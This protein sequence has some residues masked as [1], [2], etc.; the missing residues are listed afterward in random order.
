MDVSV[1]MINYNTFALAKDAVDSIFACTKGVDYEVILVDNL[2]P[3][4]SGER[5]SA[6]FG[7]K[8][9]Y[10][11]AGGNLGTSKAFNLGLSRATGKY[12]LWLNPDILL[13]DNFIGTLFSYME[14]HPDC[15]IC[16][17]NVLDFEGRPAHSFRMRAVSPAQ[18]R[19]DK[20][21]ICALFKKLFCRPFAGEYNYKDKPVEVGYV[22]GADMMVRRSLFDAVGGF[23]EDIFMYAEEV[24]FTFRAVKATGCKVVCVPDAH[25]LHLEGASF[26]KE[27]RFNERRF[28]SGMTGAAKCHAKCLGEG[29]ALA[30]LKLQRR[31]YQKF[32]LLCALTLQRERR[33]VYRT[34]FA[35]ADEAVKQFPAILESEQR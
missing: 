12:I 22:T 30:F 18:D 3:D 2:S 16:G 13:R 5:L 11:G 34:K 24:E 26:G 6:V 33:A 21:L 4:G 8:I 14:A 19:R 1:I 15:G 9:V 35:I 17:G 25:I 32:A 31:S 28:R 20:S 10:I 27:A 7:D 23:D 29:A